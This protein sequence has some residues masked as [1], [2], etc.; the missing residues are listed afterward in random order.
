MT[1]NYRV[2]RHRDPTE[3]QGWIVSIHEVFYDEQGKPVLM[4]EQP[5]GVVSSTVIGLS[6]VL[7]T[8]RQAFD[9]PILNAEDLKD[10]L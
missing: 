5:A 4:S 7:S 6:E 9:L 2:V 3:E 8:L 1:W 10:K